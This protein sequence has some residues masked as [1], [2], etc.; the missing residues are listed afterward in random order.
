MNQSNHPVSLTDLSETQ[1][2]SLVRF[3]K[4][5]DH[6]HEHKRPTQQP[7]ANLTQPNIP[8]E[9]QTPSSQSRDLR[10]TYGSQDNHSSFFYLS[11]IEDALLR[12]TFSGRFTL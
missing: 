9:S 10:L 7:H 11:P 12:E 8:K 3:S 1:D 6:C 2:E 4:L 5:A